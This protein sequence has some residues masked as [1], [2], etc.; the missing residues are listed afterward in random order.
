MRREGFA[1]RSRPDGRFETALS[2]EHR[3]GLLAALQPAIK[4][5]GRVGR[6][7]AGPGTRSNSGDD[8]A[9][10]RA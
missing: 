4:A 3:D 8:R 5:A 2:D 1:H 10:T 9:A 6:R 7:T